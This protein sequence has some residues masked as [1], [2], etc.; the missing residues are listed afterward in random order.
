MVS[1]VFGD[2]FVFK[3]AFCG[4]LVKMPVKLLIVAFSCHLCVK[5][6]RR[7]LPVN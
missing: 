4:D 1:V 2:M 7:T 5:N 3:M 6:T